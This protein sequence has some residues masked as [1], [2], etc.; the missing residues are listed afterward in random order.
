VLA[1]AV[2]LLVV[3]LE[4]PHS[5][6]DL[7]HTMRGF[8]AF[9]ICFAVLLEVWYNHYLFFRRYALQ[10]THAIVLNGILLF[11]VL[12]YVYPL[13]FLFSLVVDR[14]MGFGP[15]THAPLPD[16]AGGSAGQ[17]TVLFLIYNGGFV[18][19]YTVFALLY[20][21]ALGL[22]RELALSDAELV[23]TRGKLR[24]FLGNIAIGVLSSAIILAGGPRW[25][26]GA[27]F[28]YF[29]IGPF[30]AFSGARTGRAL[31]AL[32]A[33]AASRERGAPPPQGRGGA[34]TP[35]DS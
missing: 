21:R 4:V 3:S 8:I 32:R 2:T 15:G 10:D 20:R 27:G 1:F 29:L 31:R 9:A 6:S 17:V 16:P 14:L 33:G 18:A 26:A 25:A 34:I 11:V 30:R 19:V 23:L 5:L 12:F 7:L 24:D 13:K 28:C 22:R 35:R